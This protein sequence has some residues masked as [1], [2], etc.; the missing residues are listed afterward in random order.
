M[1]MLARLCCAQGHPVMRWRY[2]PA[3]LILLGL[4]GCAGGGGAS[5]TAPP[6]ASHYKNLLER[7][8]AGMPLEENALENLPAMTAHD[9]ESLGDTSLRQGNLNM[10]FVQYDR[11]IRL[12]PTQTRIRY[13]IGQLFLKKGLPEDALR[14]FHAILKKDAQ[15]ALAHE[16]AGQALLRMDNLSEAEKHLRLALQLN[17]E[18][19]QSHNFLGIMYDRQKRFEAAMAEYHAAIALQPEAWLLLNN[20]GMSYYY[21]GAYEKAVD[22][23]R[24]ARK[25]APSQTKISNNLGLALG[26]MGRYQEALEAFNPGGDAAQAYNNL[27]VIYLGEKKYQEAIDAFE[28]AI[29]LH[30]SYYLKANENLKIARRALSEAAQFSVTQRQ[31]FSGTSAVVIATTPSSYPA[32]TSNQTMTING[33]NFVSGATL[34]FVTPEGG[35]I[36]STASKLTFVSSS[37]LSYQFNNG[38]DVGTWSV[39]V[40]NPDGQRSNTASVPVTSGG[41]AP[42]AQSTVRKAQQVRAD[43]RQQT[44]DQGSRMNADRSQPAD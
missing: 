23:F 24:A 1:N 6:V 12:D 13:K 37:Q 39:T 16:G 7:Q 5:L 25:I 28:K 21:N 40:N 22:A 44:F 14:E 33:S 9:H 26:K 32:S 36:P 19:W 30:S 11:A 38:N 17:P 2:V 18:L 8:K 42:T 15:D 3:V 41:S 20:L 35:T 4:I 31:S 29:E 43:T 34:T 27:G 10:A